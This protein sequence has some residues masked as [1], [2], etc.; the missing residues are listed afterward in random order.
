MGLSFDAL[1][2]AVAEL[3]R[4]WIRGD[5]LALTELLRRLYERRVRVPVMLPQAVHLLR[6][7]RLRPQPRREV[8]SRTTLQIAG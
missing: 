6:A 1:D 3:P 5:E 8:G 7:R 4:D 2:E